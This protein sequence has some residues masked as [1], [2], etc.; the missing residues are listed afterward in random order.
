MPCGVHVVGGRDQARN[1]APLDELAADEVAGTLGSDQRAIDALRRNHLAEVD[2]ETVRA[3]KQIAGLEVGLDVA[4][5]D[6]AL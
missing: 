1:A 5:V 3:E 2:V 6:V 4:G